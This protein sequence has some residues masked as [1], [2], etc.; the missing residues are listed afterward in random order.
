MAETFSC[1]VLLPGRQ[2]FSADVSEVVLP[3]HDG[4]RGILAHHGDLVGLLG[5]GA[6]KIVTKG[7]DYWTA[8]CAGVYYVRNGKLT[9]LPFDAVQAGDVNVESARE[10]L[11]QLEPKYTGCSRFAPEF[12]KLESEVL[13]NKALLEVARRTEAV[14]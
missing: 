7:N 8:V 6:M 3:S 1:E 9:V 4:E 5:T 12:Q 10:Q 13:K 2:L 14:H 11:T